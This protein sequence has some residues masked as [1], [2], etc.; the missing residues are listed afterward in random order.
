[1]HPA[2]DVGFVIGR[3]GSLLVLN[4]GRLAA[5]CKHIGEIARLADVEDDDRDVVVAA[6]SDG[7]GV[8]DLEVVGEHP[9]EA[10]LLVAAGARDLLGIGGIDAVDAGALEQGIAAH[11]GGAQSGAGI[12]GEIGAAGAG[13]EDDDATLG[14]VAFGAAADYRLAHLV[15]LDRRLDAGL[16]ADLL[17]RVLH[18]QR[19]HHRRQHAHIVGLAPGPCP[20]RRPPCRGRCCRRRPPRTSHAPPPV[21]RRSRQRGRRR[22]RGRCRT[23]PGPSTPRRRA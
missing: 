12:G 22:F 21:R 3:H 5:A 20:W 19:V 11:F 23:G 9:V 2:L 4:D 14:E 16:D 13:G 8:H 18:R 17:E 1:M 6:Q 7:G 15:H 10:D